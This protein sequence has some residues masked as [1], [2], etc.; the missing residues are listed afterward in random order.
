[1]SLL[2]LEIFSIIFK[3]YIHFTKTQRR[4]RR[5][6]HSDHLRRSSIFSEFGPFAGIRA[7]LY[8]KCSDTGTDEADGSSVKVDEPVIQNQVKRGENQVIRKRKPE[9]DLIKNQE[10]SSESC[11][12]STTGSSTRNNTT[13]KQ[14]RSK[15]VENIYDTIKNESSSYGTLILEE[16]FSRLKIKPRYKFNEQQ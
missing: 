13:T 6:Q 1:M 14:Q 2:N 11:S 9:V 4:Q 7:R 10:A 5:E 12:S 8:S 16:Y 15:S 3:S